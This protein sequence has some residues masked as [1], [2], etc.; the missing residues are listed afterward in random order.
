MNTCPKCRAPRTNG[1]EC[2]QCGVIYAKAETAAQLRAEADARAAALAAEAERKRAEQEAAEEK[3]AQQT[4]AAKLTHCNTCGAVVARSASQCPHCG[5]KRAKQVGK[6]G[7]VIAGFFTLAMVVGIAQHQPH[8][9]A[10]DQVARV[11][12]EQPGEGAKATAAVAC[13]KYLKATLRD[14]DSLVI[15]SMGQTADAPAADGS[16]KVLTLME[17]RARNGFGGM[18]REIY[19]C[20]AITTGLSYTIKNFRKSP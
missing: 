20:E 4:R 3:A 9:S 1:L 13:K 14:P 5:A 16:I 6:A 15:D 17:I 12:R 11:M 2:P 10:D 8:E 19:I 18:N 7:L